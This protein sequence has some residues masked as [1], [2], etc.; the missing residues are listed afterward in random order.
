MLYD[1]MYERSKKCCHLSLKEIETGVKSGVGNH[2]E[3]KEV[4][5]CGSARIIVTT[6]CM[7]MQQCKYN[8]WGQEIVLCQG[9]MMI[10]TGD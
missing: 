6:H 3:W 8:R 7:T 5:P 2:S 9:Y 4:F 1:F 10:E